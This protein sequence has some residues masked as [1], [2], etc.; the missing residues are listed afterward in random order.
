MNFYEFLRIKWANIKNTIRLSGSSTRNNVCVSA[1][2]CVWVWEWAQQSSIDSSSLD[3][4]C[5]LHCQCVFDM[6]RRA[7]GLFLLFLFPSA[8]REEGRW[9]S[10]TLRL[11]RHRRSPHVRRDI[12]LFGRISFVLLCGQ[13]REQVEEEVEDHFDCSLSQP[14]CQSRHQSSSHIFRGLSIVRKWWLIIDNATRWIHQG[15]IRVRKI[16]VDKGVVGC[17]YIMWMW[18]LLMCRIDWGQ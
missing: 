1:L 5:P 11:C 9:D 2:R 6:E 18:L 17:C 16:G 14:I 13:D 15:L 12:F 3:C 7:R 10:S 4:Q 8:E